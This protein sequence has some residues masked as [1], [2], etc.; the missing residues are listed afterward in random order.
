MSH[1]TNMH[2]IAARDCK[3]KCFRSLHQLLFLY[4]QPTLHIYSTH[5]HRDHQN[6]PLATTVTHDSPL[7]TNVT[8]Q[9]AH[10][11][12]PLPTSPLSDTVIYQTAYTSLLQPNTTTTVTYITAHSPPRGP[13]IFPPPGGCGVLWLCIS[14]WQTGWWKP[15]IQTLQMRDPS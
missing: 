10:S 5:L 8:H 4:F 7:T 2:T 13:T 14:L 12:S 11:Q 9:T 1:T 3:L 6:R 15:V